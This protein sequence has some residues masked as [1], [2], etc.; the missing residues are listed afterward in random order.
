MPLIDPRLK[1][2]RYEAGHS[3]QQQPTDGTTRHEA[4]WWNA[5][6]ESLPV[7]KFDLAFVPQ[8]NLYNGRRSVQL[9]VLDWRTA[10]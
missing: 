2:T 3:S 9:K 5:G 6:Q 7:G 1:V 4:V 10:Q 8:I